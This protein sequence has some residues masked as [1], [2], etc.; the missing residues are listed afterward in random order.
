MTGET[1]TRAAKARITGDWQ[2]RFPLL[3]TRSPMKLMKRHGPLVMGLCLDRTRS[4][5]CYLPTFFVHCL[6]MPSPV[7]TLTL[8]HGLANERFPHLQD[9][10]K[11]NHHAAVFDD[12]AER[13]K[14]QKPVLMQETTTL[15]DV[16]NLYNE[17]YLA[18][19]D[20]AICR[21]PAALFADVIL[22]VA[23]SGYRARAMELLERAWRAMQLWP[24]PEIP[25]SWRGLVET[26][27]GPA[28]AVE[29]VLAEINQHRLTGIPDYGLKDTGDAGETVVDLY[30]KEQ[31]N[32][33][34]EAPGF[35]A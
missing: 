17:Y 12:C 28:G 23:A 11:V 32:P 25:A 5:D 26:R 4:N 10:I 24:E 22:L 2:T 19:R 3:A 15:S 18:R 14:R 20:P 16:M 9:E 1:L 29:T 33:R 31:Q 6:L 30:A 13:M 35:D 7:L 27:L 21:F 8:N 34:P